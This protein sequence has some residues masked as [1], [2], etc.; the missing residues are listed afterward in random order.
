MEGVLVRPKPP[1]LTRRRGRRA[2]RSEAM[3]MRRLSRGSRPDP[4]RV[5]TED[6]RGCVAGPAC[7]RKHRRPGGAAR[8]SRRSWLRQDRGAPVTRA[9]GASAPG[10]GFE[11]PSEDEAS[12][13]TIVARLKLEVRR[14]AKLHLVGSS[15][16]RTARVPEPRRRPARA[17]D[18][19]ALPSRAKARGEP[20]AAARRGA[21]RGATG[22]RAVRRVLVTGVGCRK[23]VTHIFLVSQRGPSLPVTATEAAGARDS[24]R[25][26]AGL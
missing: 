6:V 16:K 26:P 10:R 20:R 3:G 7:G 2:W 19:P 18:E 8:R 12:R 17:Q 23:S 1:S 21:A 9:S 25:R 14:Q 15:G 4:R 5:A 11:P 24:S 22:N 13:V